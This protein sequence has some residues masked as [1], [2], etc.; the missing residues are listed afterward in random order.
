M[1]PSPLNIFNPGKNPKRVNR[2]ARV[3]ARGMNF[4][5]IP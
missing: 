3:I 5:K 1:I 4:V 2:R